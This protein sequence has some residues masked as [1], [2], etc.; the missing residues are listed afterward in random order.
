MATYFKTQ[1]L[2]W[3]LVLTLLTTSLSTAQRAEE[4]WKLQASLGLNNPI[5]VDDR[6]GY[7]SEYVNFPTINLGVQ[8]MFSNN[9][10]AKLDLGYNRSKSA[11]RSKEFKLN[12]T[13]INAQLLYDFKDILTFLPAPIGVVG[14]AG[15]GISMTTPLGADTNNTYTYP[16][17][18]GGLE[19]HYRV[20]E[21]L[22]VFVDGSYAL[23]LSGKD[24]YRPA[25]HGYSFNGDLMYVA[26][27]VSVSLS[28]CNYCY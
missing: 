4:R 18:L 26:I 19:L 13:R 10:G 27:G 28:G 1:N 14:H 15:P 22:S 5:D 17:I 11:E 8:H 3:V 20:S 21:T 16:N 12:Y 24:K 25:V 6:D 2:I 23:S 7:F 9:L